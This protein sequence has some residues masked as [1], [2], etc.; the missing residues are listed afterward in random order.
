MTWLTCSGWEKLCGG[1]MNV[2]SRGWIDAELNKKEF[3][4]PYALVGILLVG[5]VFFFVLTTRV[6]NCR[7]F[8]DIIVL[9]P[10]LENLNQLSCDETRKLWFAD[11]Q[12]PAM[13]HLFTG[14]CFVLL[15]FEELNK[16]FEEWLALMEN[17]PLY[18][19]LFVLPEEGDKML[20]TENSKSLGVKI[21]LEKPKR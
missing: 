21:W 14:R 18:S 16:C 10:R 5:G 9:Q 8:R 15:F 6:L 13:C 12:T 7:N 11:V 20:F 17:Q 4:C 1:K 3:V 19:S 2:G